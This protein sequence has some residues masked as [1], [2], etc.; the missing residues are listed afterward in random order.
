MHTYSSIYPDHLHALVQILTTGNMTGTNQK[1]SE[2]CSK[3]CTQQK[4]FHNHKHAQQNADTLAL[5]ADIG[6]R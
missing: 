3:P 6:C 5:V 1:K 2:G 4:G